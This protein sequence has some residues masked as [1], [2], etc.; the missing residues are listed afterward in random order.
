[1]P[2]LLSE[3]VGPA[4]DLAE[5]VRLLFCYLLALDRAS[6]TTTIRNGEEVTHSV[7]VLFD[8]RLAVSY[9]GA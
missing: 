7:Q 3:H 9:E 6:W 4:L 1:M 8:G 2:L 5:C